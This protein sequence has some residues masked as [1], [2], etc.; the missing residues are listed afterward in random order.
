MAVGEGISYIKKKH[1]IFTTAR[2]YWP[3]APATVVPC[4]AAVVVALLAEE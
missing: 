1:L 2:Y 3:A 4:L